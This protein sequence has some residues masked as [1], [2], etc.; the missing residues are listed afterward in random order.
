MGRGEV[1]EGRRG[2]RRGGSKG[3]GRC[4]GWGGRRGGSQGVGRCG[5][6]WAGAGGRQQKYGGQGQ[7]WQQRWVPPGHWDCIVIALGGSDLSYFLPPT[8]APL[9][10]HTSPSPFPQL[11][12]LTKSSLALSTRILRPG[13]SKGAVAV[14]Y[15]VR[16]T[17][18][19][20]CGGSTARR[21]KSSSR[22]RSRRGPGRCWLHSPS[23]T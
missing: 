15:G 7:C 6:I 23:W 14:G 11:P 10:H 16:S 4:G 22:F 12:T 9:P 19:R 8:I 17:G 1:E 5:G 3:M 2:G 20:A 18:R 13:T 21:T